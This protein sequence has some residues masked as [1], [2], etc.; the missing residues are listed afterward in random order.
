MVEPS[1]HVLSLR[2]PR[3]GDDT[4]LLEQAEIVA[5]DPLFGDTILNE[6][7]DLNSPYPNAATRCRPALPS[8]RIGPVYDNMHGHLVWCRHK[9][10][11]AEAGIGERLNARRVRGHIS[12][13]RRSGRVRGD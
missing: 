6:V 4:K 1:A 12:L 7:V 5:P 9:V 11:D 10:L 13:G 3:R 2:L 8:A